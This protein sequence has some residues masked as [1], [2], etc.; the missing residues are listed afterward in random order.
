MKENNKRRICVF[1][2]NRANYSSLISI[3]KHIQA[4]DKLEL[5][6]LTGASVLLDKYGEV[7]N[8]I[9]NDGFKV[10]ERIYTLIEGENPETMAK[11]TG[12]G[13]IFWCFK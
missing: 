4:S 7:I 9:E 13:L 2:G 8:L 12:V 1:L 6:L 10:N 11:T 3:M 5:I